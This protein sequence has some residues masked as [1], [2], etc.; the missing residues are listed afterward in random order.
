[1]NL[2]LVT[3]SLSTIRSGSPCELVSRSLNNITTENQEYS[4]IQI[5]L[6]DDK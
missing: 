3:V 1:M 5:D 4:Y 2:G 6:N